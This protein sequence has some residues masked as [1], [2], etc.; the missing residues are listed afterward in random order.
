MI[1]NDA[2]AA[3]NTGFR[4]RVPMSNS[5]RMRAAFQRAGTLKSHQARRPAR[6]TVGIYRYQNANHLDIEEPA[7]FDLV[8]VQ[9]LRMRMNAIKG[10]NQGENYANETNAHRCEHCIGFEFRHGAGRP[11]QYR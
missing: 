11:V 5:G 4:K 8:V 10:W 9:V 2:N 6:S 3:I 1:D 7:I